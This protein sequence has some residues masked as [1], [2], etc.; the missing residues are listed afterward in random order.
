VAYYRRAATLEPASETNYEQKIF[1]AMAD[2]TQNHLYTMEQLRVQADLVVSSDRRTP[3]DLFSVAGAMQYMARG[4]TD[5]YMRYVKI[6]VEESAGDPELEKS[7]ARFL[8]DYALH[9]SQDTDQAIAYKKATLPE[10]WMDDAGALNSFAWWCFENKVNLEEAEELARRG[11]EL[12]QSGREKGNIL[13]TLAEI[14]NLTGNCG[15][16]VE[17]M[18]Q[19]V[20]ED[21][22]NE[23]F[24]KQLA[25]FEEILAQQKG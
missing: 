12:A 6:A 23:Y 10:G 18:R 7:R 5:V 25:R 19:A 11:V 4:D 1:M 9:V 16:A 2:G 17:M 13:D 15:E 21:P 3:Q 20:A 8:P 24:Q 22:D 14:C